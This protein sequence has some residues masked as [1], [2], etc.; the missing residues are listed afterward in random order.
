MKEQNYDKAFGLLAD[1]V[2]YRDSTKQIH[3]CLEHIKQIIGDIKTIPEIDDQMA[4]IRQLMTEVE[5]H[6]NGTK[7][8]I[9]EYDAAKAGVDE[10]KAKLREVEENTRLMED[11][12]ASL[13]F[14]AFSRKKFLR[15]KI[16]GNQ[17]IINSARKGIQYMESRLSAIPYKDVQ[18]DHQKAEK[19]LA[20]MNVDYKALEKQKSELMKSEGNTKE[21]LW[22]DL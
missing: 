22:Y 2:T 12:L 11:E 9:T 21:V 10:A 15:E 16:A 14:F 5:E 7:G 20:K 13:G 6:Y 3:I 18:E 17:D 19:A 1:I 4:E 8:V